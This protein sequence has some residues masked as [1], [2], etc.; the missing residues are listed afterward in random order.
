MEELLSIEDIDVTKAN[1]WNGIMIGTPALTAFMG[2]VHAL[3]R[4]LSHFGCRFHGVAIGIREYELRERYHV[5]LDKNGFVVRRYYLNVSRPLEVMQNATDKRKMSPPVINQAYIDLKMHLLIK[6]DFQKLEDKKKF[7]KAAEN[8]FRTMRVAGGVI[9]SF[10][11]KWIEAEDIPYGYFLKDRTQE[12]MRYEGDN[13]LDKIIHALEDKNHQY[14]VLA[15]G[16]RGLTAPGHVENQRDSNKLHVFAEQTYTLGE[17]IPAEN[18]K[19][20][21][22]YMYRYKHDGISYLCTQNGGRGGQTL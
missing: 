20:I 14:V 10:K 2:T 13:I 5:G 11:L 3:E 17:Y 16:F 18:I 21:N 12:M 22:E 4:K 6:G 7:L 15:N 9:N 8:S 19:D 1:A